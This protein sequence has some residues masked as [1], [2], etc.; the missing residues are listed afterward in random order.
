MHL[1]KGDENHLMSSVAIATSLRQSI[2]SA[3]SMYSAVPSLYAD[4]LIHILDLTHHD[5][6]ADYIES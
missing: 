2:E 5:A 3:E 6:V 1:E 4:L